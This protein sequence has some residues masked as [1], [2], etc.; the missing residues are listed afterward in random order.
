MCISFSPLAKER[1][2]EAT[3]RSVFNSPLAEGGTDAQRQ[4][5]VFRLFKLT[6]PS[7]LRFATSPLKRRGK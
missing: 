7:K 4:D 3:E 1:C 2:R 6:S 5:G